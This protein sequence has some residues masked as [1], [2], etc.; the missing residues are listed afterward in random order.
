MKLR[1]DSGYILIAAIGAALLVTVIAMGSFAIA[2]R[3]LS[4]STT[5]RDINM[6]YQVAASAAEYEIARYEAG[7][8]LASEDNKQL[9]GGG[10]TYDLTYTLSSGASKVTL[11]CTG[12][13]KDREE[14]I[15]IGYTS[16]DPSESIYSGSGNIFGGAA[17]N[18]KDSLI[19]GPMYMTLAK[20]ESINSN[21]KFIDGP[22]YVANGQLSAKFSTF[23][24]LTGDKY[25]L[26]VDKPVLNADPNTTTTE[27]PAPKIVPPAIT[28]AQQEKFRKRAVYESQ[29]YS[30][31][32][33]IGGA[34]G[35]AKFRVGADGVLHAE[36]IIYVAGVATV[37]ATV[38]SYHGNFAIYGTTGIVASGRL[39]PSDYAANPTST[40]ADWVDKYYASTITDLTKAEQLPQ[41]RDGYCASLISPGPINLAWSSG[42]NATSIFQFCGALFSGGI[43][44]FQESLRGA[45]IGRDALDPNKK[46]I[47]ATQTN[48]RA[49]LPYEVKELFSRVM[50]RSYWVRK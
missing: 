44:T 25:Q 29:Y 5:T 39:V 13:A 10:G 46:T 43:V 28:A 22:L 12:K 17:F 4:D 23:T 9:P 36:G 47:L 50:I 21:P 19:I 49:I 34:S 6:A 8:T 2:Q 18:S 45:I 7:G 41:A 24:T 26:Y 27:M 30:G 40:T 15:Q 37:D 35:P 38:K 14:T 42:N 20:S 1:N 31:N 16:F 33:N 3:S 32:T 48:L 11:E